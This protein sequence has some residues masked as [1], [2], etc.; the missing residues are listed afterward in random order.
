M[1]KESNA[2][3]I[4]IENEIEEMAPG[5]DNLSKR[6][7]I[8]SGAIMTCYVQ[9]YGTGLDLVKSHAALMD[10]ISKYA[11][12]IGMHEKYRELKAKVDLM[13]KSPV[14]LRVAK[15]LT[16]TDDASWNKFLQ[17]TNTGGASAAMLAA[18]DD[19]SHGHDPLF[20]SSQPGISCG[21]NTENITMSRYRYS[22]ATVG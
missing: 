17:C 4:W 11:R 1:G 10:Q 7:S 16:A 14:S 8:R 9:Y 2:T 13:R 21:N 6:M 19:K 15:R 5:C 12:D 3:L 18:A 22:A 20:V